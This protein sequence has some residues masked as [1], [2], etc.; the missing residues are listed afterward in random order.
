MPIMKLLLCE[1]LEYVGDDRLAEGLIGG[2]IVV[3]R[4]FVLELEEVSGLM[5]DSGVVSVPVVRGQNEEVFVVNLGW[6]DC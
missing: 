6:E 4:V 3:C 2:N 5:S 1:E